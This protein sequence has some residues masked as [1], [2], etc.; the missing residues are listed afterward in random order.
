MDEL[1]T[2]EI[3]ENNRIIEEIHKSFYSMD[4]IVDTSI[5]RNLKLAY[6]E[7]HTSKL[8][9]LKDIGFNNSKSMNLLDE[10]L[11]K[12]DEELNDLLNEYSHSYPTLKFITD[13]DIIKLCKKYNLII[14][15]PQS[16]I[17]EIPVKNQNDIVEFKSKHPEIKQYFMSEFLLNKFKRWD[18]LK[19]SDF[20]KSFE[21]E[22]YN[23]YNHSFG[24][25]DENDNRYF[26]RTIAD[27]YFAYHDLLNRLDDTTLPAAVSYIFKLYKVE[28]DITDKKPNEF[29]KHIQE[30]ANYM[31]NEIFIAATTDLLN[32][33]NF[34]RINEATNKVLIDAGRE[35]FIENRVP[36]PIVFKKLKRGAV[37]LTAWGVE[38]SD[39]LV[40]NHNSN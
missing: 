28:R 40:V 24:L 31:Q 14:A 25:G 21:R 20:D 39:S 17:G 33:P 32:V 27:Q 37:I 15:P 4:Q 5:Q 6:D 30:L 38:A 2:F 18:S 9:T 36:D 12:R 34:A 13:E 1:T 11:V 26:N 10:D 8:K 16:Y 29:L 3:K 19:E 22:L 7:N 35:E 23:Y